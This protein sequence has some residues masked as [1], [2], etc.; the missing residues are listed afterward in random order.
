MLYEC[1]NINLDIN[2]HLFL[3]RHAPTSIAEVRNEWSY[4]L[5]PLLFLHGVDKE[6]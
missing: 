1:L 3:S 4:P 6:T 2:V 5:L